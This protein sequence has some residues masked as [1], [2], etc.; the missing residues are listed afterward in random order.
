MQA[1]AIIGTKKAGKTTTIENLIIELTTRGYK[2]AAIKH[3][4][5]S[6]FT[7]DTPEKDT[8]RYAKAG[9]QTIISVATNETTTIEKTTDASP[10]ENL[11]K[12]CAVGLW[13]LEIV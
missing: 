11:L 9:A 2:T 12:K 8:W 5:E 3:I 10:L 6:N 1:I 7:I 13:G 4:P